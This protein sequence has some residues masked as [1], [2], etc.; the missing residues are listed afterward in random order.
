MGFGEGM[1]AGDDGVACFFCLS[2]SVCVFAIFACV[3]ASLRGGV[4]WIVVTWEI[5]WD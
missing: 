3:L 2:A 4:I 5:K 1:G